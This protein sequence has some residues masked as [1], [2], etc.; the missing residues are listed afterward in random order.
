MNFE[1]IILVI[2]K[3]RLQ[4]LVERFNTKPQARFYIEQAGGDFNEFE[5][6]HGIFQH[7]LDQAVRI[8]SRHG[9]LKVIERG[10]LPNYI[11]SEKDII[12]AL[13]QDG[14]IANTA[15][16]SRGQPL[17]GVNPDSRRNDGILLPFSIETLDDAVTA[18][19][20]ESFRNIA[21]TMAEARTGDGQSLLAFNDLFI[22]PSSH[23]SARY[24][25]TLDK[26]SEL[27]SSSGIIVSTG[28]G[29]TGWLSSVFNMSNGI[30]ATFNHSSSNVN[31]SMNWDEDRL[32]F[33][34]REP[35][36]SKHSQI[37]LTAGF[38]TP[39][40]PLVLESCMP[41]H[42]VIF[43]DGIEADY[44]QFNAGCTATISL[45]TQ[46]A[47]MVIPATKFATNQ[48]EASQIS[49]AGRIVD[50]RG[51]TVQH[52]SPGTRTA[53]PAYKVPV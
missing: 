12:V 39:G 25:I 14:L 38:V 5:Q 4:Q 21:V 9:K 3:T 36:L 37:G 18:V 44:I 19:V 53:S 31:F 1:N 46:K 41:F 26:K 33:A 23:T 32:A 48:D 27:Q 13:G 47:N 20:S 2:G 29:S 15:K 45:S 51:N 42:G 49:K 50:L 10:F 35:F 17:V 11:F 28:A 40:H 52:G 22:G 7:A 34:V 30:Q 24:K 16:Y 8:A 43:S 6:E